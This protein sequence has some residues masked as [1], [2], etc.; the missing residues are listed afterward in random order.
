MT[1]EVLNQP[2]PLVGYNAFEAD[3]ALREA[4]HREAGSWGLERACEL[5]AVV[6]SEEAQDH[7]RRAQRNIPVLHTHDRYGNRIDRVE[8]DPSMHW[9]LRVGVERELNSLPWRD[10][11]PGAHA[12][13]AGMFH[14][15]NQ[16]DTGPCCP[17]SI[18]YAAVP[19][20]RQDPALAAQW[21]ARLTLPDYDR[22]A[23]AGMVMT[24]KQGG[25]D[26]RA[27][28]TLAEP[29]GDGWFELTGHKWFCTHPVFEVFFTL[30][31]TE[32]GITC[33]LAE[34]PH[35]GFRLQRLKDKLG[36]RC[37][38]S[39]EVEYEH[40]PARVLG[41]EGRGTAVIVEQLIWTR[42]DTMTAVAGMMRRVVAEAIWHA[43]HRSAFGAP[44]ALQP[45]MVNVL[46]DLA[47]ESEAATAATLRIA[48]AF[49]SEDPQQAA[50]RRL[51]LAVMKYWVCKRGAPLAAEAL[52][53]LGG[54]GYV[55]EAPMAQFY[56]DIQLGTVWEGSGNV[57]ALD[58]LRALGREAGAA[59]AFLAE[60]ELAAG[61]D[62]R[63]DAHLGGVRASLAALA[64]SDRATAAWEARRLVQDLALA[65]QA[66]LLLRHAPAAVADAFCAARLGSGRGLAFGDLPRGIDGASI[67]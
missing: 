59:D 17:L 45:A 38:A 63:F 53:C 44:L 49:D 24:E 20:M 62:A 32:A 60:C 28:T 47:L 52:E 7:A 13:R 36:G 10:P 16:L 41:E 64:G 9:M 37:L 2:P 33:F 40:L 26:L 5:G 14:L 29:I 15:Y 48:G 61:A 55:E 6:A 8:Y 42:L 58:V 30:A 21:E 22:F 43:R 25:S 56:R 12:L 19:T 11:R 54:N 57:I 39:G 66:S 50:F 18:N 34:R 35:P 27:N 46:A 65:L 51:G 31:Q 67:V 23:Q 1:H 3:P 4:V